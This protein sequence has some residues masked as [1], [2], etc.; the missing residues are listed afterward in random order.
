[1]MEKHVV[2]PPLSPS[3]CAT[4]WEPLI[5]G[6]TGRPAEK[7]AYVL[8]DEV[9][10]LRS[11]MDEKA[12]PGTMIK[13]TLPALRIAVPELSHEMEFP[14]I[15]ERLAEAFNACFANVRHGC[16]VDFLT[17]DDLPAGFLAGIAERAQASLLRYHQTQ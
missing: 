13:Y 9:K 17:V 15:Y 10:Y 3:Q 5:K 4:K 6:L 2:Q 12:S 16:V 14:V 1:M 7:T 11:I 8:E